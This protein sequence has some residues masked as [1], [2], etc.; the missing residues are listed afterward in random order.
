MVCGIGVLVSGSGVF[1]GKGVSVG[2]KVAVGVSVAGIGVAVGIS[3]GVLAGITV[4]VGRAGVLVNVGVGELTMGRDC[5]EIAA[6]VAMVAD[7]FG[8][9]AGVARIVPL[10]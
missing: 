9:G 8:V 3:V 6:T 5:V 10:A 1:V 2:T 7:G 4:G